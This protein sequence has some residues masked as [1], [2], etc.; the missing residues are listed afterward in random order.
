MPLFNFTMSENGTKEDLAE[1]Y[2]LLTFLLNGKLDSVN[3]RQLTADKIT[4]GTLDAGVVTIRADLDGGAYIQIDSVNGL[5]IN[6]GTKDTFHADINGLVTMIGALIQSDTGYP[7]IE[8]NSGANLIGAYKDALHS[9]NILN[10]AGPDVPAIRFWDQLAGKLAYLYFDVTVLGL[11][12]L[13]QSDINITS[14]GANVTISGVNI[15][16]NGTSSVNSNGVPINSTLTSLQT[17]INGKANSFSGY[18]GN[19]TAGTS[20]L[21]FTNGILTSVT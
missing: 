12:M 19:V 6:D 3:I 16:L 17:Q 11:L 20:T 15:N 13:A 9:L 10:L 4:T 7:R 5:V 2:K 14:D 1:L 21:H 18:T 8:I